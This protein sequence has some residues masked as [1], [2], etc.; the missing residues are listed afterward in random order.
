MN[1]IF[2]IEY[3]MQN[4]VGAYSESGWC[5]MINTFLKTS[6]FFFVFYKIISYQLNESFNIRVYR[7]FFKESLNANYKC[8]C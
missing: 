6:N 3:I 4:A 7:Y 2:K 1:H 5:L 8:R